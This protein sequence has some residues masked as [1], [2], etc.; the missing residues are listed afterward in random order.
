VEATNAVIKQL[1]MTLKYF[2]LWIQSSWV[3]KRINML[4]TSIALTLKREMVES[5]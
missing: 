1:Y 4:Q 3:A 2:Y 5:R